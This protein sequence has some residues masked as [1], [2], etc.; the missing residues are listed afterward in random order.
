M[1]KRRE[2]LRAENMADRDTS[3]AGPPRPVRHVPQHLLHLTDREL[4]ERLGWFISIRWVAGLAALLL[5]L[6]AWY[7][8]DIRIPPRPVVLTVA[9]LFLYN[10]VFLMLVTD[11][12]RRKRISRRFLIGCANGQIICD[13][14]TLTVLMHLTG[15]VENHFMIFFICPMIIASELLS[16]RN[17]YAHAAFGTILL[18]WVAWSEYAGLMPH[19]EVVGRVMGVV[20]YKNPLIVTMFTMSLS[21]LLFSVVFLGGSIAARL[22]QR[23]IELEEA[24]HRLRELEESKSFHMRKTSHELRA[25]LNAVISMLQAVQTETVNEGLTALRE[26]LDRAILRTMG[27]SQLIEDLHRYAML[28]DLGSAARRQ[29]VDLCDLVHQSVNL[30]LPMARTSRLELTSTLEPAPVDGDPEALTELVGNLIVNAIQYT[31]AGGRIHVDLHCN[32]RYALLEVT[33]TGIGMEPDEARRIF[34]E[35]Y[36][37]PAA[38]KTFRQGTGMGLPIIQR[39]AEAHGGR[40]EVRSRP[41]E[42]STFITTLPLASD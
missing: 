24:Y 42:G 20:N 32:N 14:L 9:G 10:A 37:T 27:L 38:K 28:R 3:S 29:R 12:Y 13:L 35:F 7:K 19:V 18:N 2:P 16:T 26:M 5:V 17:A 34:E 1:S 41:N 11:A 21:L 15:G 8:F 31:P 39:I 36:R 6:I 40:I 23:E 30:Y 4:F 33:D 22:R 25:P